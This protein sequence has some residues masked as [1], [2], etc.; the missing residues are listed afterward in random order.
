LKITLNSI[1]QFQI[2]SDYNGIIN[3]FE[4]FGKL[5]DKYQDGHIN[6]FQNLC[7]DDIRNIIGY[8]TLD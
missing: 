2:K 3:L 5:G 6:F 7:N 1:L 4:N 8:K